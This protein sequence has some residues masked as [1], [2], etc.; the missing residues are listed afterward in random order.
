MEIREI[1][2]FYTN[3]FFKIKLPSIFSIVLSSCKNK[4]EIID[5]ALELRN[6]ENA[7]NFRAYIR[8]INA[9]ESIEKRREMLRRIERLFE[10]KSAKSPFNKFGEYVVGLIP[11]AYGDYSN[12]LRFIGK[13][14]N[15][16]IDVLQRHYSYRNLIFLH[17]I[18]K[19][20]DNMKS[21]DNKVRT[22]LNLTPTQKDLEFY[23]KIIGY[24][25]KFISPHQT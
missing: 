19:A 7:I 1:D 9:S 18:R 22:M 23:E 21:L 3:P 10:E 16:G 2:K 15:T 11:T 4:D 8:E 17:D 12:I 5:T 6:N 24:Q 13:G 14:V 20:L 25:N